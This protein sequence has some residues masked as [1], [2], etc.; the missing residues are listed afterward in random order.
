[1]LKVVKALH[2][3]RYPMPLCWC[4]RMR[5]WKGQR[6]RRGR[7]PTIPHKAIFSNYLSVWKPDLLT[8]G[9]DL[10]SEIPDLGSYGP[11]LKP[12]L[13]RVICAWVRGTWTNGGLGSWFWGLRFWVW[14][15]WFREYETA[16]L[17]GEARFGIWEVWL[18]VWKACIRV[19]EASFWN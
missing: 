2:G 6:P 13:R 15:V 18:G 1:M 3:Q 19:L 16:F 17:A 14:E 7:W 12:E 8:N 9:P 5:R 10:R 4:V 11:R